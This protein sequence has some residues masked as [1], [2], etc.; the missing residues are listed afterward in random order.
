[1]RVSF[2]I[3]GLVALAILPTRACAE[4]WDRFPEVFGL[5]MLVS[6]YGIAAKGLWWFV[7]GAVL[8]WGFHF[9]RGAA[10]EQTHGLWPRGHKPDSKTQ[11][12]KVEPLARQTWNR[13]VPGGA[14]WPGTSGYLEGL[15]QAGASADG[16]EIVL[17]NAKGKS[18]FWA[19]L[20]AQHSPGGDPKSGCV[21]KR[22]VF[23]M[24]GDSMRIT[25]LSRGGYAIQVLDVFTGDAFVSPYIDLRAAGPETLTMDLPSDAPG[26]AFR[27]MGSGVFN[28]H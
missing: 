4:G 12:G 25:N 13:E 2:P 17:N 22:N 27:S 24:Q 28:R 20:C 10:I 11:A 23:V 21:A 16:G 18:H 5:L 15:P 19:R 1:M 8:T 7:A 26:Q 14:G 3:G 6:I 9:Y